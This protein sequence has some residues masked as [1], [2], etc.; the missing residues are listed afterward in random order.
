[1]LLE[2]LTNSPISP[3]GNVHPLQ[4]TSTTCPHFYFTVCSDVFSRETSQL[5]LRKAPKTLHQAH[6]SWIKCSLCAAPPI[7]QKWTFSFLVQSIVMDLA[8]CIA[9]TFSLNFRIFILTLREVKQL[10]CVL[11]GSLCVFLMMSGARKILAGFSL[12]KGLNCTFPLFGHANLPQLRS[13]W[14]ISNGLC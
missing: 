1:M 13:A 10:G 4:S 14:M 11:P 2:Y 5:Q 7:N 12:W 8:A 6:C 3:V 9:W